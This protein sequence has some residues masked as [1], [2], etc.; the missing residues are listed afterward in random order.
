MKIIGW[1]IK[2][3]VVDA[4]AALVLAALYML[5]FSPESTFWEIART[6]FWVWVAVDVVVKVFRNIN[7]A[8]DIGGTSYKDYWK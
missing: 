5:I 6:F 4:V 7:P 2:T 3:L 8:N 1:A